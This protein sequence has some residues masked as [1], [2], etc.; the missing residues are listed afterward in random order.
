MSTL[1]NT[2][3]LSPVSD[4]S[5]K[6]ALAGTRFAD[7]QRVERT[8]STNADLLAA[9]RAGAG[10]QALVA[11]VQDAG[12]GRLERRWE[13]PAGASLLLS[14]LVRP[15]FPARGPHLLATAMGLA[16]VE[17]LEHLAGL[18]LGLKW[19]NDVVA[20]GAGPDGAD[21]KLGG[22]L[23]ELGTGEGGDAVVVGIGV[24]LAWADV[25]FP[26]ELVATATAVDLLG[27]EVARDDLVVELLSRFD[28]WC[29][30]LG[31]PAGCEALMAQYSARCVTLGRQ[32]RVELP[33]GELVGTAS[34][35][36]ASGALVVRD[37]GGVDH[38]VT[39]GDV[40]HLRPA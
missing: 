15:P 1:E 32:V 7:L 21:A 23:A 30:G 31:A 24:N 2:P 5:A 26:P 34:A 37:D 17:S 29:S 3:Y 40:V 14:V 25:G 38:V 22:L 11:D 8:G 39:V 9:A 18:R 12:R 33:V 20:P 13:A 4:D 35:L 19:P 28:A 16:A 10:E 27:A 36:D 6:A